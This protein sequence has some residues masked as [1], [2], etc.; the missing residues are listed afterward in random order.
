MISSRARRASGEG[1]ELNMEPN[2]VEAV[3]C[4][5]D[6][7]A[8]LKLAKSLSFAAARLELR[9]DAG[10]AHNSLLTL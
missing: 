1:S 3:V 4:A 2:M 8:S 10:K 7:W 9:R 5:D 6:F